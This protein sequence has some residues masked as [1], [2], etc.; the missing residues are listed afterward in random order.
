M[1][2]KK[3]YQQLSIEAEDYLLEMG[4]TQSL[5]DRIF[6]IPSD[7]VEYITHWELKRLLG[8]RPP[9]YDEWI[10]SK[11][12]GLT[13][14]EQFD[15]DSNNFYSEGYKQYLKKKSRDVVACKVKVD[16]K[17]RERLLNNL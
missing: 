13:E 16:D 1:L 15:L 11:C 14:E 9:E 8:L 3:E 6:T 2:I 10:R 5:V 12:G 7:S 17:E 4:A